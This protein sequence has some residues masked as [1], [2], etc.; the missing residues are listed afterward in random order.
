MSEESFIPEMDYP[1]YF[2]R[3][4]G[5]RTEIAAALPLEPRMKVLD[6]ATGSAYF[7]IE[8]AKRDPT[9]KIVGIDSSDLSIKAADR[10]IADRWLEPIVSLRRMDATRLD[11]SPST[12]G[13]V[14]NFLTLDDVHMMR[15]ARGVREAFHEVARV[16]KLRGFFCLVVMLP[17]EAETPSQRLECEVSSFVRGSTWLPAVR[18][19]EFLRGAGFTLLKREVHY[20]HQK[21]SPD[22]AKREIAALCKQTP[23]MYGVQSKTFE[24]TWERFGAEIRE[25]GLGYFS[26]VILMIARRN[27]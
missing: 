5:L 22:Q 27:A 23:K 3:L 21:M 15:E 4:N 17:E 2:A 9:L 6:V 12:F 7:A 8:L 13:L 20:T 25:H 14:T 24:E 16:L 11:F 1:D 18:Y 10:N 26:R 19:Q